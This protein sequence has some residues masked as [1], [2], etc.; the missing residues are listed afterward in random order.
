M[1]RIE[2]W[3]V[4][5]GVATQKSFAAAARAQRKSPQAMTRAV[6]ALE[7]RLGCRLLHRTTRAV[8]LTDDGARYLES[9][10]RILA[11]IDA[12][13]AA[14]TDTELRGTVTITAPILFG[15]LHVLPVVA[16][17][18]AAHPAVDARLVLADRVVSLAEEAIDVAIRVGDLPDSALRATRLGEVRSVVCASPAYLSKHGTPRDLASLGKHA[19]IAFLGTTPIPDRWAFPISASRDRSVA[20]R[21]R[22]VVDTGQAAID[23]ALAGIGLVR[24][25]SYQ[26]AHLVESKQLRIVLADHEPPPLPVHLLQLPGPRTRTASAF[27]ELAAT[28]IR[29]R[30]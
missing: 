25:L 23:A 1:D 6:Q 10:R 29:E 28:R 18:L 8:S 27:A 21:P 19:C 11:E 24:V 7:D 9:Y 12:V 15:Q 20:V 14:R 26:V 3:R 22:L 16:E 5:V 13:E 30:L 2:E 17:M 4:F